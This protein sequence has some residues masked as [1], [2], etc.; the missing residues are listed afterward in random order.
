MVVTPSGTLD[1]FK[2]FVQLLRQFSVVCPRSPLYGLDV[3]LEFT[4]LRSASVVV[5]VG[6]RKGLLD[7]WRR[8]RLI[9]IGFCHG[10]IFNLD[11]RMP[12]PC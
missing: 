1:V 9:G 12:S 6:K 5:P 10:A 4:S 3:G 8:G 2:H 11:K 7:R